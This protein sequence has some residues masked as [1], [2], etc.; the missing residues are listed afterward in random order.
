MLGFSNPSALKILRDASALYQVRA[1]AQPGALSYL[2]LNCPYP[3][4]KL[5]TTLTPP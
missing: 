4:P 3:G 5:I 2:E 1:V